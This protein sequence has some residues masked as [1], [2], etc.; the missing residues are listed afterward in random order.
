MWN[1]FTSD[2]GPQ[3]YALTVCD[4]VVGG[5]ALPARHPWELDKCLCITSWPEAR[6]EAHCSDIAKSG[7][8]I[9]CPNRL[10]M[11]TFGQEPDINT[12]AHS[13][14]CTH[15]HTHDSI[16]QHT[17]CGLRGFNKLLYF[18]YI[19]GYNGKTKDHSV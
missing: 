2:P 17:V 5:G 1:S 9:V 6:I 14:T 15:T 3:A 7:L 19:V 4:D 18:G 12:H 11:N 16:N 13:H 10:E 8:R